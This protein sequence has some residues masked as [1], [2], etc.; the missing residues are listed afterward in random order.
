MD[1][2]LRDEIQVTINMAIAD[3][4]DSYA[5]VGIFPPLIAFEATDKIMELISKAEQEAF[6]AGFV[7]GANKQF[8][9]N[10]PNLTEAQE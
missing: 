9:R 4:I 2:E 10:K 7:E 3:G 1:A 5:D 6:K 8:E